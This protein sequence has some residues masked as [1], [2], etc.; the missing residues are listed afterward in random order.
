MFLKIHK[1]F[2]CWKIKTF[3]HV[4]ALKLSDAVFILLITIKMPAIMVGILTLS[5]KK[6]FITSG[7]D[8]FYFHLHRSRKANL[9]SVK[10]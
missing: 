3:L 2:K 8:Y 7:Q 10:L 9:L 1:T 5:M 6:S 4:L